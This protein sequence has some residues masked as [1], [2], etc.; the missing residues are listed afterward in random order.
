MTKHFWGLTRA[1]S[2]Y[3]LYNTC[4]HYELFGLKRTT[5]F[6]NIKSNM[7]ESNRFQP[8][9]TSQAVSLDPQRGMPTLSYK[10]GIQMYDCAQ[11][12]PPALDTFTELV[13]PS[14]QQEILKVKVAYF[15]MS[16]CH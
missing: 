6:L 14:K 5:L 11:Y 10:N 13:Q 12:T 4:H 9:R 8:Y 3:I 1:T 7:S 16:N 15:K 2:N